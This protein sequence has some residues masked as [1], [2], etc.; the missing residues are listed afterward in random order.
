MLTPLFVYISFYPNE[1]GAGGSVWLS[2]WQDTISLDGR[3]HRERAG[4]F[5]AQWLRLQAAVEENWCQWQD[6]RKGDFSSRLTGEVWENWGDVWENQGCCSE[7]FAHLSSSPQ[8]VFLL[9]LSSPSVSLEH[10]SHFIFLKIWRQ[11]LNSGDSQRRVKGSKHKWKVRHSF[12]VL[13]QLNWA[14]FLLFG[15]VNKSPPVQETTQNGLAD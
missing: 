2:C 15:T 13:I 8:V 7:Y 9:P 5:S 11:L 1:D 3:H 4:G 14:L 12:S 10:K 6:L